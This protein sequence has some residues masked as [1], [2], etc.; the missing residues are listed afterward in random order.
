MQF[1]KFSNTMMQPQPQ[2]NDFGLD[3]GSRLPVFDIR[4]K[5]GKASAFS[6]LSQNELAK[7]FFG[8]GFF[9]VSFSLLAQA[10][11]KNIRF[12]ETS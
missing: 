7:E 8:M 2:G 4:L 3:L 1:A 12:R 9:N 10:Y 6:R 5:A 11:P